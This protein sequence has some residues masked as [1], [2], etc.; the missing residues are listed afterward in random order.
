MTATQRFFPPANVSSPVEYITTSAHITWD[1]AAAPYVDVN[2]PQYASLL[3][4]KGW[5]RVGRG[6][7]IGPTAERP[8]AFGAYGITP[9]GPYYDTDVGAVV[10]WD[11]A[12]W[13]NISGVAA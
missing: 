11:G 3:E 12:T 9:G 6:M 5:V 1:P 10:F 2:V 7:R 13:R 8:S 4:M